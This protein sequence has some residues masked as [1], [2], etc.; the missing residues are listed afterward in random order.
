MH[1]NSNRS[2]TIIIVDSL[3][4]PCEWKPNT[5]CL[6]FLPRVTQARVAVVCCSDTPGAGVDMGRRGGRGGRS[7]ELGAYTGRHHQVQDL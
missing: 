3:L 5:C 7:A 2:A 4:S 6:V 1:S